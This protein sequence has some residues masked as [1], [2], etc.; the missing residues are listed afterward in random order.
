MPTVPAKTGPDMTEPPAR[1]SERILQLLTQ[2]RRSSET[3]SVASSHTQTVCE[4]FVS[5]IQQFVAANQ[6]V[7]F[8]LP[9]YPCKSPNPHKVLGI[10]PDLAE[11]L[12]LRFLKQFCEKLTRIYAPG[13]TLLICSDG[14]V[15]GDLIGVSDHV[16][17]GYAAALRSMVEEEQLA[18]FE[19]FHLGQVYDSLD[20]N[21]K[22]QRL[23]AEWV[24][25]LPD[26]RD[27]LLG[28]AANLQLYR[29][30]T[31]FLVEDTADHTGSSKSALQRQCRQ[32]ALS[33]I[34]RSWAWGDV[35]GHTFPNAVR[36]SIH[37]QPAGSSKF[38]I[39]LSET[40]DRWLTPWHG[41]S[42]LT[43][44]GYVIMKHDDARRVGKLICI[45]GMPSHYEARS[46]TVQAVTGCTAPRIPAV[47]SESTSR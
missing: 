15:F 29:G 45:D 43:E 12:S 4:P 22:R 11:R 30:I 25:P 41:V 26:I 13:A 5:Q 28:S 19:V 44:S 1:T 39:L 20:G 21:Q 40:P 37:P 6:P 10:L 34:Q 27:E 47:R 32:R 42:V 14:H 33:V 24:R 46:A 3:T 9:G 16:I 2:Y 8:V 7:Q 23:I 17:D 35:L 36:L 38:G 31:R 18:C